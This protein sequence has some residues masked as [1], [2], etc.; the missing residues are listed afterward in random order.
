[1]FCC[2]SQFGS[3]VDTRVDIFFASIMILSLEIF[4]STAG[5]SGKADG[6]PGAQ[7]GLTKAEEVT[8]GEV[9][10]PGALVQAD[11]KALA[12]QP[13]EYIVVE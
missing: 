6:E 12:Y 7:I 9:G 1:L 11:N 10:N 5:L 13:W 4:S 3:F 8:H 2:D